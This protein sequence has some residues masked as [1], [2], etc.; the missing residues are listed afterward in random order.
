MELHGGTLEPG[1]EIYYEAEGSVSG[2]AYCVCLGVHTHALEC[3]HV[4]RWL[5]SV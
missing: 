5:L 1:G 4:Y 2:L 3:V